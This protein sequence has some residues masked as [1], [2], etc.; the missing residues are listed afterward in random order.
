MELDEEQL[1]DR[2]RGFLS[3]GYSAV[4]FVA[5]GMTVGYALINH[6]VSPLYLRQ[7]FIRREY[8]RRGFGKQA[9][10]MLLD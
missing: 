9:F 8:R 1:R 4:F 7:F 2:M 5:E 3:G 6:T 10:E